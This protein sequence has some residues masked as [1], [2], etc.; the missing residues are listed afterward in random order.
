MGKVKEVKAYQCQ[1]CKKI[2]RT[3]QGIK[4][5]EEAC[6]FNPEKNHCAN[7]IHGKTKEGFP[8]CTCHEDFIFDDDDKR[9][10]TYFKEC[11]TNYHYNGSESPIPYTCFNFE[12]KGRHGFEKMEV[13]DI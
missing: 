11:D 7:C 13:H 2:S 4:L 3:L 10:N 1:F 12:S 9:N 8:Y 5:H 6:R